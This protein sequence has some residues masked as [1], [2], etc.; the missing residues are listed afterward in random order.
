[1]GWFRRTRPARERPGHGDHSVVVRDT[2]VD[3]AGA[4]V[5]GGPFEQ[6]I[7]GEHRSVDASVQIAELGESAGDRRHR[8]VRRLDVVQLVPGH[9][10]GHGGRRQTAHRVGG[11]HRVVTG[12]LVVV[13]E[14][15]RRVPVLAPPRRRD[16][17][18]RPPF[19]LP[20][21]G[22]CRGPHVGEPVGRLDAHVDV[23]PVAARRLRPPDRA[24]LVEHLVGDAGDP[25]DR[26]DVGTPASGSRSIRHSSGFSTS[27]RREFHGWNST[28]D[29][30]TA[31]ITAA[32]S[33]TQSSSA[34]SP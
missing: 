29:I 27:A 20:G 13:D 26:G 3:R 2:G 1:M 25:S 10:R 6:L 16:V 9:R 5:A 34:W 22:Q 15:R 12:V 11:R 24:E 8:A 23:H 33:V 18:W 4:L 21:E 19:D 17:L 30:C 14:H 7:D 31:Q 32:S 28:V